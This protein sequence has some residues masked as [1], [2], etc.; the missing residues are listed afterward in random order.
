MKRPSAAI[1]IILLAALCLA[2]QKLNTMTDST[3]SFILRFRDFSLTNPSGP[4][5]H[6]DLANPG[7]LVYAA[8][9]KQGIELYAPHLS[10][11]AIST[12]AKEANAIR[13]AAASGGVRVIR[14]APT[15]RSEM[16]GSSGTYTVASAA[17][18]VLNGPVKLTDESAGSPSF[19]ATGSLLTANFENSASSTPLKSAVLSG[20]VNVTIRQAASPGKPGSDV[21]LSAAR[22]ILDHNASPPTMVLSGGVRVHGIGAAGS[23]NMSF[24]EMVL[25]LNDRD[26]VVKIS[27]NG[28][29]R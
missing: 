10:I 7:G 19:S 6:I 15:G 12:N 18:L 11:D 16:T 14:T 17:K 29:V 5:S 8:S 25:T 13:H 21:K 20:P 2:Q 27:G 24:Q 4:V 22:L 3:K 23:T 1:A 26:E 28:A 9:K